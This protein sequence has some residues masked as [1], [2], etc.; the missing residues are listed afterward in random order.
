MIIIWLWCRLSMSRDGKLIV[1]SQLSINCFDCIKFVEVFFGCGDKMC[2]H[3][4]QKRTMSRIQ[5][6]FMH[7]CGVYVFAIIIPSIISQCENIMFLGVPSHI[8]VVYQT[9]CF[10]LYLVR[11]VLTFL[12][13]AGV[14]FRIVFIL[15]YI[16]LHG[17]IN[18]RVAFFVKY[19]ENFCVKKSFFSLFICYTKLLGLPQYTFHK[20]YRLKVDHHLKLYYACIFQ[21]Q[22]Q[23]FKFQY[24][25]IIC[26]HCVILEWSIL[27]IRDR[28]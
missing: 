5:Y 8:F 22:I 9:H 13:V 24:L 7:Y 11:F 4:Q 10:I 2:V 25:R 3:I 16:V 6:K 23:R 17:K 21:S 12:Y 27:C 1:S 18:K 14:S 15:V 26:V 19:K 28:F 20:L